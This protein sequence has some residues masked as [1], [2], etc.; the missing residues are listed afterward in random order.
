MNKTASNVVPPATV[1]CPSCGAAQAAEPANNAETTYL[2]CPSCGE[3][4]NA[5]RH[6]TPR[7][8]GR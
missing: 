1:H 3:V 6:H 2:R 5:L 4:W 7:P 8:W